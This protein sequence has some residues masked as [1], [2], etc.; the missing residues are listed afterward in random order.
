M[1]YRQSK[2]RRRDVCSLR[3]PS[4]DR[5]CAPSQ[6]EH[7]VPRTLTPEG[8]RRMALDPVGTDFFPGRVPP[9]VLVPTLSSFVF[10]LSSF[11]GRD[12]CGCIGSNHPM[13]PPDGDR[14]T[15]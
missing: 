15:A 1:T 9:C 10:R 5:R 8:R 4:I 14:L 7:P 3:G 2:G 12:D 13:R 11:V 6:L